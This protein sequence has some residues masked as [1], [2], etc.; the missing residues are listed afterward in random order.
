MLHLSTPLFVPECY[1]DTALLRTLLRENSASRAGLDA[2]F[3]NHQH[4]IGNVGNLMH[5]QG[6]SST[7]RRVLG[8]VDLDRKFG[9]QP[10]LCEFSRVLGGSDIREAASYAHLQHPSRPAQMLLVLNP[11]FETWLAL[12]AAEVGATLAAYGIPA[13]ANAF[14]SYSRAEDKNPSSGLR[15]LLAAIATAYHPAYRDLA[16]VVAQVMDLTRPL[17]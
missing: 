10:Y 13:E 9:Q 5:A 2:G 7:V 3:V 16:E 15:R 1:A 4:G 8:M 11:V 17:P 6:K 12:R 14:K